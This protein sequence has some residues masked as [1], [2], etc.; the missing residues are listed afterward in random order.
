MARKHPTR[1]LNSVKAATPTRQLTVLAQDPSITMAN[2][3]ALT[4]RVRVPAEPTTPGPQGNRV[5]VIDFDAS[6]GHYYAPYVL[7]AGDDEFARVTDV[8][9][10]VAD[11]RFHAQNVYAIAM[12]TLW[13]FEAALGRH[14]PWAFFASKGHQLNIAPHAFA[15]ANAF[16]SRE[17][18]GLFLGYIPKRHG[19]VFTCLS[20]DVVTHETTHAL[21]DGMRNFYMRPSSPDQ[22][23]FHEGFADVVAILSVLHNVGVVERLLMR[24]TRDSNRGL[25][26]AAEAADAKLR[27][28]VLFGLAEEL[29]PELGVPRGHALRHSVR[30]EPS[31]TY[32]DDLRYQEPHRRGEI[33]VAAMMRAF[34]EVWGRRLDPL[35]RERGIEMNLRLVAEEAAAAAEQLLRMAIRALDYC[36]PVDLSFADYLSA[37]ATADHEVVPDDGRYKY[38]RAIIEWF[39]RFGIRPAVNGDVVG[40]ALGVWDPPPVMR[41]DGT[42]FE[43][44]KRDPEAVFQFIWRNQQALEIDTQ[45]FTRVYFVQPCIRMGLDRFVVQETVA[46]YVQTID[47]AARDLGKY[48]IH[49]ARNLDR[50]RK[51]RLY[52]GGTLIFDEFGRLKFHIG[53]GVKSRKQAARLQNLAERGYF[54]GQDEREQRPFAALHRNRSY[55]MLNRRREAW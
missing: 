52:G 39:G 26:S 27:E 41:Y 46:E 9:K 53:S 24:G 37:L 38:R 48:G 16:Y 2:G 33:L 22:A 35:G 17:D 30:L 44:L 21:L 25:I 6:R 28:S 3:A 5:R 19:T 40:S 12:S 20:F 50:S 31:P 18:E 23:A 29:G 36:P 51:V 32:M 1:E 13:Q 49:K 34:L 11:P 8:E 14:V 43:T 54:L 15:D 7:P 47:L 45:A 42:H 10:L 55:T 4:T